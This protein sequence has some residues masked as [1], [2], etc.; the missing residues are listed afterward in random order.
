VFDQLDQV[1]AHAVDDIVRDFGQDVRELVHL[2]DLH[3]GVT[4]APRCRGAVRH[5]DALD[6][7]AAHLAAALEPLHPIRPGDCDLGDAGWC[8]WLDLQ[9][10]AA[11]AL[12]DLMQ[13]GR[14]QQAGLVEHGRHPLGEPGGDR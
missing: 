1:V 6:Q 10:D 11:T 13:R 3:A 5:L 7:A 14:G 9:L 12:E 8:A 2:P 4:D